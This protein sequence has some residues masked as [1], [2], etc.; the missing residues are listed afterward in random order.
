MYKHKQDKQMVA[1]LSIR[2]KYPWI[3]EIH[4]WG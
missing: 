1:K 3:L 2:H 4:F